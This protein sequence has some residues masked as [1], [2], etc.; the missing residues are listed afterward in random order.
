LHRKIKSREG[1]FARRLLNKHKDEKMFPGRY[2]MRVMRAR[3][4]GRIKFL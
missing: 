2:L 3:R 4:P 1:R